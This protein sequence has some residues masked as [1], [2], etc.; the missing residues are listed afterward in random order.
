VEARHGP[1][2]TTWTGA[3]PPTTVEVHLEE[4]GEAGLRGAARGG[5]LR[6]ALEGVIGKGV[7]GYAEALR[8][9]ARLLDA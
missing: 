2:P 3:T 5:V 9:V 6:V 8:E 4:V 7:D 1:L